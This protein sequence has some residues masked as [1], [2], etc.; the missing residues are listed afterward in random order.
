MK[1]VPCVLETVPLPGEASV[2]QLLAEHTG[3]AC[4]QVLLLKQAV[5]L[6]PISVNPALQENVR[7]SPVWP[8]VFVTEPLPGA[9]SEAQARG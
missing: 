6:L 1:V 5:V 3:T 8:A 7:T 9:T 4:V 2:V